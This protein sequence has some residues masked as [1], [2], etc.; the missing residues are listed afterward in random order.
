MLVF[1][2]IVFVALLFLMNSKIKFVNLRND[3]KK[4]SAEVVEYRRERN[5]SI[6]NDYTMVN[7]PY[8]RIEVGHNE[9]IIVKLRYAGN[10]N[11][12]FWIGEKI[13]VF[14][15]EE[16]LLYW[17]TYNK[18]FYKYFPEKWSFYKHSK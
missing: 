5:T 11:N 13:N 1:V 18:G 10:S 14:W 12:L 4:I 17:D 6:R 7:Y 15:H 16:K 9:T 8:V 2:I 3:S